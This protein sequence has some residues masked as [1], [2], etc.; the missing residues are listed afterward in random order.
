MPKWLKSLVPHAVDQ[1]LRRD[2][3]LLRLQHDRRAVRV[4]GA[5]VVDL[6]PVH[7]QRADPDVRLDVFDKMA[8]MDLAVRIRQRGRDENLAAAR[9][10]AG[11]MEVGGGC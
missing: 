5:D 6:V 2:A 1:L 7:A 11:G 9:R 10:G 8:D 3:F 4:V